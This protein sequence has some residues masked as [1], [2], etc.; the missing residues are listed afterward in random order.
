V[1]AGRI[2]LDAT[3]G[4]YL[5]DYPEPGRRVTIHQLLNHTSGIPS[6]T[7]LGPEF[8]EKS[9]LDLTHEQMLELFAADS[10]EF[11]PGSSWAYNNS[12]YYLLGMIIEA[13]TGESYAQHVARTQ[14]EPLGLTQTMYCD[15][16]AIVPHRA[17]GYQLDRG[18]VVNAEPLSMN[19]PGAAGALCSTARDLVR[20]N[21]RLAAGDV[22]RPAS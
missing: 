4:D 22:V 1:E 6:Y 11:E 10:L 12:G 14:F 2:R 3:I 13:V 15:E 18:G 7:G 17:D 16:R 19:P 21:R 20:W 5:P 8:W 9:R